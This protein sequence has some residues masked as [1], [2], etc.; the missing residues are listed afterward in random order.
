MNE[1][2]RNAL[3]KLKS[4]EEVHLE[5]G[6][7]LSEAY[8]GTSYPLDMCAVAVL[9]RSLNLF[10][11]FYIMVEA[12]NLICAAS[13]LRIQLDNLLRFYASFIVSDPHEFALEVSK[14]KRISKMIDQNGNQ[15]TDYYLR[16]KLSEEFSWV[17][18]L[19]EKTSGYIHF[20]DEHIKN[21]VRKVSGEDSGLE[22]SIALG[23][24]HIPDDLYIELIEAFLAT[25]DAL[26]EYVDGWIYTKDNPQ[27]IAKKKRLH[28]ESGRD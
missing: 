2:L 8:G 13:L 15:M 24:K 19:Y 21:A 1:S 18:S 17:S 10:R 6:K 4:Y 11:G 26:F 16:S 14:G 7:K 22:F 20:S 28:D 9:N 5:K 27:E 12:R 3:E 23:D 25:T